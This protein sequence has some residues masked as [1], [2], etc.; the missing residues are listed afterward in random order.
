MRADNPNRDSQRFSDE[1]AQQIIEYALDLADR[2]GTLSA[3]DIRAVLTEMNVPLE[4]QEQALEAGASHLV[5]PPAT[6]PAGPSESATFGVTIGTA[7]GVGM[8]FVPEP[9]VVAPALLGLGVMYAGVLAAR[10]D[11]GRGDQRTRFQLTNLLL[12]GGMGGSYLAV[13]EFVQTVYSAGAGQLTPWAFPLAWVFTS[14]TGL[15]LS[16]YEGTGGGSIANRSVVLRAGRRARAWLKGLLMP[17]LKR[18]ISRP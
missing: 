17:S 16:R 13:T 7:T 3:A 8:L 2:R 11:L 18:A 15:A 1:Q 10:M 12:W 5:I 14:V 9:L 4:V 6:A